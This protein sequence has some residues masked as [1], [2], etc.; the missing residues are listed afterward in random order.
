MPGHVGDVE[1][2]MIAVD[3]EIIHEIAAE[4]LRGEQVAAKAVVAVDLVVFRQQL[5]LD[6]PCR[7]FVFL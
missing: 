6:A 2:Q 3:D 4:I 1:T 5:E 7:R